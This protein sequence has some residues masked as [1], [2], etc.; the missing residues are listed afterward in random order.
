[1]ARNPTWSASVTEPLGR[2]IPDARRGTALAAI[3]AI[4]TAIFASIAAAV[5]LALSDGLRGRPLPRTAVAGGIV[6]AESALYVSNNQVCPL[7]PLAEELG[8]E[9]GSVVDMFLPAWAARRIPLVAG[10]AAALA[11][12]LNVRALRARS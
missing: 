11:L 12:V 2:F 5:V 1:M 8:A 9:R 4:H 6:L 7:T 3:K 10:S